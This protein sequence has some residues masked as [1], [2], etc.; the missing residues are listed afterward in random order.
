MDNPFKKR[1]TEYVA[2]ART[3]LPLL[4]PEPIVDFFK[5]DKTALLEKLTIVVGT[6]GCGKT[7]IARV[8]EFD[9]LDVLAHNSSLINKDLT[10]ALGRLQILEELTP[11]LVAY[12]LPMS[13]NFRGI[14]ELPY[15]E[16]LRTIL[17][18][19]FV[20]AKAV[21]G[22]FRQLEKADIQMEDI[23]VVFNEEAESA[24]LA[25]R[26]DSTV[27][28][29][30]HAREIESAIFRAATA[31]IAPN[32]NELASTFLNESYDV[33]ENIVGFRL[34][35]GKSRYKRTEQLFKPMIIVDD[36][37]ELH[38]TQFILLREWLKS[39]NIKVARWVMCRPDVV[40]PEDFRGALSQE[41]AETDNHFGT[42][43]G[44]DYFL[45]LVQLSSNRKRE[46][47]KIAQD[48]GRRY[49]P[50]LPAFTRHS[51]D[52]FSLLLDTKA[53]ALS[54]STTKELKSAIRKL[55]NDG[56][57]SLAVVDAISERIPSELPEDERLATLRILL[58]REIRRT[59]QLSLLG[60][61]AELTEPVT[62]FK[63]AK[64]ALIDGA[65]IQLLHEYERPYY[66][67]IDKLADASN[68]NIEQ[69]ISLSSVLIDEM[70][71][72]LVRGKKADI[73]ATI[74]HEVLVNQAKRI[75]KEWD[76]PYHAA[77]RELVSAIADRCKEKTLAPNAPLDDGANAIGIPQ[78]EFNSILS[79]S[80]RLT[81]ILHYA[82]AYKALVFVP[83]YRCK[84]QEWCLLELGG[85]PCL[86]H[87]LTLGRGGFIEDTLSGLQDILS[88]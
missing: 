6:P 56:H 22:W 87:G 80:E 52:N 29:R 50:Q 44:R 51:Y 16:K 60:D 49:L 55:A 18:R 86:A 13:T 42:S 31:L 26:G 81:R 4:S 15:S 57:L 64:P 32:E 68:A 20:Q 73:S 45:K 11:T 41:Q 27:E 59:P 10:A 9:V 75:I 71:A 46:F 61:T 25:M 76:F 63:Q 79:R 35:S 88:E 39:R 78:S 28:F 67:G 2:E 72:K 77:V 37:H 54:K 23:E 21:L 53:P 17:L 8:L 34:A 40:S 85:V 69:F 65:R 5:M 24:K 83:H 58:H 33:F 48:I 7:T 19:S 84:N 43:S 70:L 62:D 47:R 12:R 30:N 66:F 1:A 14:W 82:F 36:A 74:Q 3:F 38:P